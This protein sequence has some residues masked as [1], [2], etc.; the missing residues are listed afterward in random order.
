MIDSCFNPLCDKRLKYLRDGRVIRLIHGMGEKLSIEHYW[1]CGDCY[2]KYDFHFL[3]D[4]A[5]SLGPRFQEFIHLESDVHSEIRCE[6]EI[7]D[8]EPESLAKAS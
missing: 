8:L 5:V 7:G 1:L 2:E 4:D 6:S 3:S